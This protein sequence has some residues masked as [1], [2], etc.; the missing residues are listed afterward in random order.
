MTASEAIDQSMGANPAYRVTFICSGNICRSPMGEVILKALVD[1]TVYAD[2]VV[3]DSAGL[4]S[5]HVGDGADP[6]TVRVLAKHGY[7]ASGH[8]VQQFKP[9]WLTERD[10]ILAADRGHL[11]ELTRLAKNRP[12]EARVDYIRSIDP[13]AVRAGTLEVDDPW[14]GSMA[15]FER[16]FAEV[17]ASCRGLVAQLPDLLA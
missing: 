5:W 3:V 1:D 8:I 16:T 12:D 7:D 4:G 14:Y 15:D 6:R 10:L 2:R 13:A 11:R 17:E 9:H